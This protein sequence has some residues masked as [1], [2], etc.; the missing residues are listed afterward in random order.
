MSVFWVSLL[1]NVFKLYCARIHALTQ[2]LNSIRIMKSTDF[3][4][5]VE[6]GK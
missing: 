1:L 6:P 2:V 3:L 5:N 4:I